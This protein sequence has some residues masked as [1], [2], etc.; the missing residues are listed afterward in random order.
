MDETINMLAHFGGSAAPFDLPEGFLPHTASV[1]RTL[2]RRA[3]Y[4]RDIAVRV[5]EGDDE[6][7][8]ASDGRRVVRFY[9]NMPPTTTSAGLRVAYD[10]SLTKARLQQAG[11]PVPSGLLIAAADIDTASDWYERHA[12]RRVVVKPAS[13]YGG[14]GVSSGIAS[15]AD[16]LDAIRLAGSDK[17]LI[18]THVE[19]ADYRVFVVG[20]RF[21]GAVARFPASVTGDGTSSIEALIE[22]KNRTRRKL[23]Y[24]R[25]NMIRIDEQTM[26]VLAQAG[27]TPSSVPEKGAVIVLKRV[28]NVSM[29]GDNLD[30][31]D[32]VH[33]DFRAIAEACWRAIPGLTFCGIDLMAEDITRP[34]A[35]QSL[36]VIEI[37]PNCDLAVH[38]FTTLDHG[39]PTLD[40]A[41]AVIDYVFP[42]AGRAPLA[43][44]EF[45][46]S[47]V[48]QRVGFRAW[49]RGEA[50][51]LGVS[52]ECRNL[53]D[54]RVRAVVQGSRTAL[55]ELAL[56]CALG[57]KKAAPSQVERAPHPPITAHGL[58][59]AD[60]GRG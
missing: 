52:G 40:V 25:D 60:A 12:D 22:A 16:F 10:K 11:V 13:G 1:H 24:I 50:A 23:P 41:G 7:W 49:L 35:G 18:E 46:I 34:A 5:I 48:V 4:Q 55:D 43:T 28:A 2:L 53:P 37:N 27:L 45:L 14:R 39:A 21:V 26:I 44:E 47:G 29:G 57:P 54:G 56:R 19:G 32:K 9:R 51:L 42:E 58:K 6:R 59:I 30:V 20:G 31:T 38:Q 15:K 33:P 8:I 36:G 17:V 3:C